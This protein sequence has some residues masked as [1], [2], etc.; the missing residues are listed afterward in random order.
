MSARTS[1]A[2]GA[3]VQ[4]HYRRLPSGPWRAVTARFTS[5]TTVGSV[6]ALPAAGRY[7]LRFA[8]VAGPAQAR[9][10]YSAALRVEVV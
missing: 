6:L 10:T 1:Y 4:V 3:Q 2:S 8:R 9:T 7:E 5:T